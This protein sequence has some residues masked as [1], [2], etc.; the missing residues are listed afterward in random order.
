MNTIIYMS[1]HLMAQR[2]KLAHLQPVT[3]VNELQ[4]SLWR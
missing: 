4:Y 3:M 1:E 2:R